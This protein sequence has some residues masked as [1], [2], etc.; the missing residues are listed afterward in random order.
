MRIAIV[1][2]GRGTF[3][4]SNLKYFFCAHILRTTQTAHR[5]NIFVKAMRYMCGLMGSLSQRDESLDMHAN[6]K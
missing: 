4:F 1:K 6:Q 5:Y 2:T 3:Q